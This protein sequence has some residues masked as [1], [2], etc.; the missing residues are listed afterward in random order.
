MAQDVTWDSTIIGSFGVLGASI[1]DDK[2]D[3]NGKIIAIHNRSAEDI[4]NSKKLEPITP[5]VGFRVT[6]GDDPTEYI[7]IVNEVLEYV[8]SEE[9]GHIEVLRIQGYT[10]LP[11]PRLGSIPELSIGIGLVLSYNT[12]LGVQFYAAPDMEAIVQRKYGH[13][14]QNGVTYKMVKIL[15]RYI[16]VIVGNRQLTPAGGYVGIY[17]STD[18][19]VQA[20]IDDM[21]AIM[22]RQVY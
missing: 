18:L 13:I 19:P 4:F 22:G 9:T 5:G 12:A 14:T 1:A 7:F 8:A 6:I 20:D 21:T 2:E 16:N 17:A 10:F 3:A 15:K 11:N